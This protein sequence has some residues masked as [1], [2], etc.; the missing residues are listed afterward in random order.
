MAS[1]R[2]G[3]RALLALAAVFVGSAALAQS[4]D[5]RVYLDLDNNKLTAVDLRNL[6]SLVKI[7]LNNN[8]I[9]KIDF[10]QLAKL[11]HIGMDK[12]LL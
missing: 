2:R 12:N 6:V 3:L 11:G 7:F 1:I 9:V 8:Q 5:H 10:S 4:F